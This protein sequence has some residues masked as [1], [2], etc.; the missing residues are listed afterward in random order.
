MRFPEN[1]I[2]AA[3]L[4][5]PSLGTPI[6]NLKAMALKAPHRLLPLGKGAAF[7][8]LPIQV[9]DHRVADALNEERILAV[10]EHQVIV[11]RLGT[12][13]EWLTFQPVVQR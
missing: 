3:R 13:G 11:Q 10:F 1:T 9:N 2:F 6:H 12:V 7:Q 4:A 8:S 5:I